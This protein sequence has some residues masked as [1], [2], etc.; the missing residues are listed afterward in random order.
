MQS[1]VAKKAS[2][3]GHQFTSSLYHTSQINTPTPS[4]RD[5]FTL[6]MTPPSQA[7]PTEAGQ[8]SSRIHGI[9][10]SVPQWVSSP[11]HYPKPFL[12]W[13]AI[14]WTARGSTRKINRA[15]VTNILWK[16]NASLTIYCTLL[17]C[18]CHMGV[19]LAALN[20]GKEACRTIWLRKERCSVTWKLS[21]KV[22]A[23]LT[24]AL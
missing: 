20:A 1:N 17:I 5:C 14:Y 12:P 2:G 21:G 23:A 9:V 19:V 11:M 3:H 16:R 4:S 7:L 13:G 15:E 10:S 24:E 22:V 6:R 8:T 18:T